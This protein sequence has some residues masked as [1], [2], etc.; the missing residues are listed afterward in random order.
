ML[1]GKKKSVAGIMKVF[2][3]ARSDL[4]LLVDDIVRDTS[5]VDV[6]IDKLVDERGALVKEQEEAIEALK[7]LGGYKTTEDK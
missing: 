7:F 6:K 5:A 4:N 1:M 3:K 2:E